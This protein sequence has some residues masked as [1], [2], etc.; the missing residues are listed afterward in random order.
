MG[1]IEFDLYLGKYPNLRHFQKVICFSDK[2]YT[3]D[4]VEITGEEM[5]PTWLEGYRWEDLSIIPEAYHDFKNDREVQNLRALKIFI[6]AFGFKP[7]DK[8][9][10]HIWHSRLPK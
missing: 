1:F 3:K 9:Y 7:K 6:R 2:K 4:A 8:L 5:P 10:M